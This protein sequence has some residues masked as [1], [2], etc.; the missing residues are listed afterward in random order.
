LDLH[1]FAALQQKD[2]AA[3]PAALLSLKS[4]KKWRAIPNQFKQGAKVPQNN[5][6][7]PVAFNATCP[8][9]IAHGPF[10]VS[11]MG[12]TFFGCSRLANMSHPSG[13]TAA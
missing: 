10:Y 1:L 6:F 3:E 12:L 2:G 4:T 8:N 7:P 13:D 5:R 11:W 9:A